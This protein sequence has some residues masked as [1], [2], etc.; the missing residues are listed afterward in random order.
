MD[1]IKLYR[2][3]LPNCSVG[4]MAVGN[5]IVHTLERPLI[6]TKQWR[7]GKPF[8]S[9]V[10]YGK[11]L[12]EPHSSDK[13]GQVWALVNPDLGVYHYKEDRLYDTDRYGI[14]IHSANWVRQI[15]GCIAVGLN[16][17]YEPEIDSYRVGAS[18]DAMADLRKHIDFHKATYIE[19]IR[20][21]RTCA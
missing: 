11:Y 17:L 4:F 9:C 12:L 15:V 2:K 18:R 3:A 6:M 14:L 7:G 21:E 19:V 16:S 5:H 10:P 1:T 20:S 13:H 8:E